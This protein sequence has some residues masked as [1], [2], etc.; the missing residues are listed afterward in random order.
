MGS[1]TQS[2][3]ALEWHGGH[4]TVPLDLPE[5]NAAGWKCNQ[6]YGIVKIPTPDGG[7]TVVA[8]GHAAV[9]GWRDR[10]P[11]AVPGVAAE[12]PGRAA[13]GLIRTQWVTRD[14]WERR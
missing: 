9:A 13:D 10:P 11:R 4:E 2:D 14:R 3:M 12:R 8:P 5:L 6:Q 1:F 7:R